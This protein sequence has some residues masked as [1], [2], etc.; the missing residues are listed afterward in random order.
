M[1][2]GLCIFFVSSLMDD[3]ADCYGFKAI[4][5]TQSGLKKF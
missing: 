1:N 4:K 2:C 3:M 5:S